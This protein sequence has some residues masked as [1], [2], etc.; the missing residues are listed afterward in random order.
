VASHAVLAGG[1][2]ESFLVGESGFRTGTV[3][4]LDFSEKTSKGLAFWLP[5]SWVPSSQN[6]PTMPYA[7]LACSILAAEPR[8]ISQT[9]FNKKQGLGPVFVWS[10]L[11][12][13][14][15]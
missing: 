3:H 4:L 11:H 2:V 14:R 12:T 7:R 8:D 13:K 15:E 1:T 5:Q 9:I 6:S 10:A